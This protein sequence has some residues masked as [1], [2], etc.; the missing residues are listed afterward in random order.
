[1]SQRWTNRLTPL[2][3]AIFGLECMT[4]ALMSHDIGKS[5]QTVCNF[6]Q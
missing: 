5:L 6:L 2:L 3:W 1:M 4:I